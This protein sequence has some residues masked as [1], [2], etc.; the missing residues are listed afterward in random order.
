MS[1]FQNLYTLISPKNNGIP[2]TPQPTESRLLNTDE[3]VASEDI[4]ITEISINT[5]VQYAGKTYEGLDALFNASRE[6]YPRDIKEPY[7]I[8]RSK[9]YPCFDSSDYAYETRYY[10]AFFFTALPDKAKVIQKEI[11]DYRD[12]LYPVIDPESSNGR[13]RVRH[14]P[15][16]YYHGEG[17]KMLIVNNRKDTKKI[18]PL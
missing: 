16:I 6:D 13:I 8:K 2:P 15:Y 17:N 12:D 3:P 4:E 14:L 5:S 7:I 18:L 11:K 9:H 10:R 1:L